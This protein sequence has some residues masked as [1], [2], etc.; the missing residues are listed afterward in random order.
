MILLI[1][2]LLRTYS[3]SGTGICTGKSKVNNRHSS[4]HR[5]YCLMGRKGHGGV[6]LTQC[7]HLGSVDKRSFSPGMQEGSVSCA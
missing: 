3:V 4:S 5:T 2:Y 7:N 6:R 1:K